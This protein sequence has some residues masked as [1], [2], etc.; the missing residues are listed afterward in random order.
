MKRQLPLHIKRWLPLGVKR[1]SPLRMKRQLPLH[2][3]KLSTWF[4]TLPASTHQTCFPHV[5]LFVW[6]SPSRFRSTYL[7]LFATPIV[8]MKFRNMNSCIGSWTCGESP[9]FER[10]LVVR[11]YIEGIFGWKPS[12]VELKLKLRMLYPKIIICKCQLRYCGNTLTTSP[13]ISYLLSFLIGS[14]FNI[15]KSMYIYT[16]AKQTKTSSRWSIFSNL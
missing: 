12:L 15:K 13:I 8:N 16:G 6:E 1:Q 11:T 5:E 9:F 3:L 4:M 7:V 2:V 10:M 14:I